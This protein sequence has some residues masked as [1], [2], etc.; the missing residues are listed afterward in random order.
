MTATKNQSK[1]ADDKGPRSICEFL[2]NLIIEKR[3]EESRRKI[4]KTSA[5]RH[6]AQKGRS[7]KELLP[8]KIT[9]KPQPHLDVTVSLG[10]YC[11]CQGVLPIDYE[12][13]KK[14]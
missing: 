11:D 10:H 12:K 3:I 8:K 6:E 4:L 2:E 9:K 14:H 1:K 13:A 5:G 7:V